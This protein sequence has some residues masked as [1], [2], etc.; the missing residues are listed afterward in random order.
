MFGKNS[1]FFLLP[2]LPLIH[3]DSNAQTKLEKT[4]F[5]G[6]C[7][8]CME[9]PFE[10]YDSGTGWPSF[11]KPLDP[12][13][14]IEVKDRCFFTLRTKVRSKHGDSHLGYV[15]PDGPETTGLRYCINSSSLR[16]ILKEDLKKKGMVNT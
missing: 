12:E 8:W 11:T 6:G 2:A 13:N 9:H 16:F 5:A 10:K 15:F 3:A 1:N 14:I 7:F 4:T